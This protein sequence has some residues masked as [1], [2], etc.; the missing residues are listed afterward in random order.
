LSQR[1]PELVWIA[2]D[3]MDRETEKVL[4]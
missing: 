3:P 1:H 4:G 2:K